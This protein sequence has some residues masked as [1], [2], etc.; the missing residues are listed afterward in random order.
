MNDWRY[1]KNWVNFKFH[2]QAIVAHDDHLSRFQAVF[3]KYLKL[4]SVL[5]SPIIACNWYTSNSF[6]FQIIKLASDLGF[7]IKLSCFTLQSWRGCL[8]FARHA[9]TCSVLIALWLWV[10]VKSL[11]AGLGVQAE[12]I[13]SFA[14]NFCL[15]CQQA[16]GQGSR[17]AYKAAYLCP[18]D[19]LGLNVFS[20]YRVICMKMILRLI[21]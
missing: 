14:I 9:E 11:R 18:R 5:I 4:Q 7:S 16:Q 19:T 2:D 1:L 8:N 12:M 21:Q 13:R 6:H 3:S 15:K 10:A 20:L 17:H